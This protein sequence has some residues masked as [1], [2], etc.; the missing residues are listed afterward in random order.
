MSLETILFEL[1]S[2]I[3]VRLHRPAKRNAMNIEMLNE[4]SAVLSG[5]DR[6]TR[7]L[8]LCGAPPNFCAGLDLAEHVSRTPLQ[9]METSRLWHRVTD[10]IQ[11]GGVRLWK[12]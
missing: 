11:D 12:R 7:A 10:Q 6:A 8:V 3:A 5:R 1:A 9:A 2:P 4:I